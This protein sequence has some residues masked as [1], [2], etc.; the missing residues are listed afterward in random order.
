L[1]ALERNSGLAFKLYKPGPSHP[2]WEELFK[3]AKEL[4]E[5]IAQHITLDENTR[6]ERLQLFKRRSSV[7]M[8]SVR[9]YLVNRKRL[10]NHNHA[11][12]PFY[13]IW[14][15]LNAC[16]FRCTY[17]DNHMGKAYYDLSDRG[18]LT[19][20]QG[21]KMLRIMRKT[22]PALYFC[23][24]EPTIRKDL[25]EMAREAHRL[26]YF[27]IMI[28]T[29]GSLFH[30]N[31][32]K[33]EWKD[34][35]KNMDIII[36]SVDALNTGLLDEIYRV[37]MGRQV[38]VNVLA[39]RELRRLVRF[40]LVVNTV[41]MPETLKEAEAVIN[42]ANDLDIWFVPVPVNI[43]PEADKNL[44]TDPDY[45]K[46]ADMIISR[47]KQGYKMIGS[48]RL[49]EMLLYGKPYQCFPTLRPHVDFDGSIIWPC[50]ATVNFP[51]ERINVLDYKDADEAYIAAQKLI[52][53]NDYAGMA[54]NQ[55]GAN[56]CWM[57]NYTTHVY[58]EGLLHPVR[59]GF[60]K[61]V[62]EFTG[63]F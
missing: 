27:P 7:Y 61:E 14:T 35:L 54:K 46:L 62:R 8:T 53:V 6:T 59:S 39:L 15:M 60:I 16:N 29:N 5:K 9:N 36:V 50:K 38:L 48:A 4:A 41:I 42:W 12:R 22:T 55:C 57:Q 44:M 26:N 58:Y 2:D 47:K 19:S 45:K 1:Q 21:K 10:K 11:L 17:C 40:K 32:L 20:E 56:C 13:F 31:L 24:G 30:T 52:N 33:P 3:E 23:G 28:N 37:P 18:I 49:L 34:Y 63:A 25:P 51:P 43:G